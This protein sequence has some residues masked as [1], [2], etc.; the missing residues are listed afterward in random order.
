MLG[1]IT[2][3]AKENITWNAEIAN[4]KL[5]G[6]NNSVVDDALIQE[7]SEEPQVPAGYRPIE[8]TADQ[9]IRCSRIWV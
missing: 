5:V 6:N 7:S 3:R 8:I 4:A 1:K 9:A 2:L